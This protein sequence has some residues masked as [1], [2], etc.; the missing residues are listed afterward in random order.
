MLRRAVVL[1]H[2]KRQLTSSCICRGLG[3]SL[4]CFCTQSTIINFG[5]F[6]VGVALSGKGFLA[7]TSGLAFPYADAVG[8]QLMLAGGLRYG[9]AC[10]EFTQDLLFELL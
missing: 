1:T 10:L 2:N 7:V 4:R 6:L 3:G 9:L 5:F 8:V